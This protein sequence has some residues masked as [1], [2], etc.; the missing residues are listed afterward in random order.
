MIQLWICWVNKSILSQLYHFVFLSKI[1]ILTMAHPC[2]SLCLPW[3]HSTFII[4]RVPHEWLSAAL[5]T[6]PSKVLA[7][8]VQKETI[9][10]NGD[11]LCM[12][13]VECGF[14]ASWGLRF[15]VEQKGRDLCR[16]PSV[17][18]R[19]G[20]TVLGKETKSGFRLSGLPEGFT[21]C[22]SMWLVF[23]LLS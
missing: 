23:S 2:S 5:F 18:L 20:D 14:Q 8:P 10:S 17:S 1:K 3:A 6:L 4:S 13:R 21:N 15:Q 16:W 7:V 11:I 9:L 12:G 19:K 22:C